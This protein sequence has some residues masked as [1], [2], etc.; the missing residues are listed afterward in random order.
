M[1]HPD[2]PNRWRQ[3]RIVWPYFAGTHWAFVASGLAAAVSSATEPVIP[4]LMKP[5]LDK[6]FVAGEVQLW[7]VPVVLIGLFVV[8][9]AAGFVSSYALSWAA[10]KSTLRIRGAMFGKL[11]TAHPV[12]FSRYSASSLINTVVHEVHGGTGL[13][14]SAVQSLVKD[15]LTAV[16][17]LGYLLYLNWRLTLLI[18][19]LVPAVVYV[20]RVFSTRMHRLTLEGQRAIDDL[21]YVVEENILAWRIV[22]LHGAGATESGKFG[23]ASQLLRRLSMKSTVATAVVTPITQVLVAIAMSGVVMAALWQSQHQNGT[24]GNFAAFVTAMLLLVSPLKH[25]SEIAGPITRGLASVQRG[26][27]LIHDAP[28]ESGGTHTVTRAAGA[29]S[30]RDVSMRYRAEQAPALDHIRVEIAAGESVALVGPSGGGKSTFVNLVPRF[31]DPTDGQILLDGVPLAEW[32]LEALR[33][34]FALVSQDVVLFNDSV[35][36]NVCLGQ[37]L[38]RDRV[39]DALKGANLLPFVDGLPLG[40][41]SIIGHNGSELSGGQ[42]QRLAI[43]RAIYKDAPILLLD[44]ATSALDTESE[45]LVQDALAKVMAG[46]TSIVIAHRLS[47]IEAVDRVIVLDRGHV[48]EQGTHAELIARGGLFSRLHGLQFK[49]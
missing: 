19:V 1:T 6:G 46:R 44:E 29:I 18:A 13:L 12:L 39:R 14:V 2:V 47:T 23:K 25:L 24:V 11:M 38:S 31:L 37:A 22:R 34:Q 35:A 41:D 5:L 30:F 21:A 32:S 9:G 26:L 40:I 15:S 42:R 45:R 28:T 36:A 27:A 48:A 8:R 43:A 7:M 49:T 33:Q 4:A 16:A 10:N 20:M 17:L 3:L